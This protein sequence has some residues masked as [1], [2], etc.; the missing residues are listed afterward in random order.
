[1]ERSQG[2]ASGNTGFEAGLCH[3]DRQKRSPK[4]ALW[5]SG[6]GPFR[7]PARRG[8]NQ[9][10]LARFSSPS[11]H[12]LRAVARIA[13]LVLFGAQPSLP[14]G[15]RLRF[16]I[17]LQARIVKVRPILF[18][19]RGGPAL[20]AIPNSWIKQW[21]PTN[22]VPPVTKTRAILQFSLSVW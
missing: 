3:A 18:R 1:M 2:M 21:A 20:G 6:S 12:R 22:P 15:D 13:S 11:S 14:F 17:G 10:Q 8:A 4:S 5:H 16:L 9:H 19:E 7:A